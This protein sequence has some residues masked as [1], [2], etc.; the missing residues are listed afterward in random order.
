[1]IRIDT[2]ARS[3]FG[4]LQILTRG[5]FGHDLKEETTSQQKKQ[6]NLLQ[7]FELQQ[8]KKLCGCNEADEKAADFVIFICFYPQ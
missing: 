7:V 6:I 1:M 2:E 5:C 8:V 4:A 3:A